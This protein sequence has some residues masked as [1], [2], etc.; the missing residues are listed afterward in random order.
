MG[1]GFAPTWLRQVSPPPLLH[2]TTLTTELHYLTVP[3]RLRLKSPS[4]SE[5]VYK[6]DHNGCHG[7]LMGNHR[8]RIDLCWFRWPGV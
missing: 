8:W 4:I 7:T 2:R 1:M 5:T 6:I 3:L